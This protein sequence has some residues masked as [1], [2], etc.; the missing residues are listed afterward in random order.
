M[1]NSKPR[2]GAPI[3]EVSWSTTSGGMVSV[4]QAKDRWTMLFVYRGKH[5]PRCKR[6]LNKLNAVLPAWQA[7]MDVVVVS[8]DTAE[9]A[10]ADKAEFSW[11]FDLCYGLSEPE[12]RA[13]GLYVS[14]PL[15]EA[16]TSTRFAEPGAF[17]IRPDGALML[18]DISNGPAARPDLEELLDGMI[19]NI[20][21]NRPV[22]GTA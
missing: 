2:V 7:V 15:S 18:V 19:F 10:Q 9:K 6:F 21:N 5:C 14:D 12:M 3:G 16:E 4:G 11:D 22:R 20:E 13:L 1:I 8:A 17:G